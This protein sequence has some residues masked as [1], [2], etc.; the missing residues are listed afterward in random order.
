LLFLAIYQQLCFGSFASTSIDR[1]DPRFVSEGAAMGVLG[2]PS[3]DAL[4][5]ITVSPYRGHFFFAPVL[6]MGLF[7]FAPWL[8]RESGAERREAPAAMGLAGVFFA[9]NVC[10]NGW[11]GGFGIGARYLVPLIPIFGVAMLHLRGW[12]RSIAV[13]LGIVSFAINFTA[14]AVDP[15]PSGTIPRPLTQYLIPLL[16]RGEFSPSVP[17]TPPWSAATF[18][19]HTSVNRMAHDEAVVF[20]RHPPGSPESEWSSFNLGEAFFGAGDPRSL[21]PLLLVLMSGAG[22]I[23]RAALRERSG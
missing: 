22:A 2:P 9:V 16:L 13:V 1:L 19:G 10:F 6:L 18:T 21:I 3:F 15:Q 4:I 23:L 20:T 8:R 7:G 11:E 14:A 17:I 5:G 12:Q